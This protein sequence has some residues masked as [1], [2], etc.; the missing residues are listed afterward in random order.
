MSVTHLERTPDPF[1]VHP[2]HNLKA[3]EE[4]LLCDGYLIAMRIPD[5]RD[6]LGNGDDE[7]DE[8]NAEHFNARL[9]SKGGDTTGAKIAIKAPALDW[10]FS[11]KDDDCVKQFLSGIDNEGCRDALDTAGSDIARDPIREANT[12]TYILE[13]PPGQTLSSEVSDIN[14]DQVDLSQDLHLEIFPFSTS[15]VGLETTERWEVRQDNNGG[16]QNVCIRT[17][18]KVQAFRA[19]CRVAIKGNFHKRGRSTKAQGKKKQTAAQAAFAA[20][21]QKMSGVNVG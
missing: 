20:G 14:K 21:M 17:E 2:V 13:F 4:G 5:V 6:P 11:G 3:V 9:I 1:K 18:H 8:P 10:S 7:E 19:H 12:K 15:C 16:N